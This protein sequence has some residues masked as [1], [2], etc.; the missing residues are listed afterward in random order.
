M[1]SL[2]R[3]RLAGRDV[4]GDQLT[5]ENAACHSRVHELVQ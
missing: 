5:A 4:R 1:S 2:V 3:W